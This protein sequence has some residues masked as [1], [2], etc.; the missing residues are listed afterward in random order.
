MSLLQGGGRKIRLDLLL[1]GREGGLMGWY[2][3]KVG[4]CIAGVI[5]F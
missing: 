4:R 2:S 3:S 1:L 5:H